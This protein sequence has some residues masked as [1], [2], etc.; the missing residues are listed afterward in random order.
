[1]KRTVFVFALALVAGIALGVIGDRVLNAQ[2]A[3][4]KATE[5]LKTDI[6]GMEGKE[7]IIQLVEFAPRGASGRHYHPGHEA[8][9]VLEG[10]G[11]LEM[12]GHPPMTRKA[13][14]TGSIPAKQ[15]HEGKN[16]S[17]TDPLKLVVFRIHEKGQPITV[18]VTE[19]HFWK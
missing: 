14:D 19:P 7:I 13:G 9:Y 2:Q 3:P 16:A 12:E 1:M 5:L 18:R 17:T 15:V 6:V 4:L 10:T 8:N 11:V